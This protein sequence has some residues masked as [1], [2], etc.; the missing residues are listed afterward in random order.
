MSLISYMLEILIHFYQCMELSNSTL[1]HLQSLTLAEIFRVVSAL[2]ISPSLSWKEFRTRYHSVADLLIT[3][4][5]PT[6][7]SQ[8]YSAL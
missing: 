7:V 4:F 3:R 2:Q 6:A 1:L 5:D 8:I